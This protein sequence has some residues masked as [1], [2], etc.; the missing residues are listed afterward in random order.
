MTACAGYN[1]P[2]T[3]TDPSG[4]IDGNPGT[5]YSSGKTQ[6]GDESI[7]LTFP[8]SL[9]ATGMT[10]S[11]GASATDFAVMYKLEYSTDGTTFMAFNPA[12][13]GAGT[14]ELSITFPKTTMKAVKLSQTGAQPTGT[15]SWW[16]IH[17]I[18]LTGCGAP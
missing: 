1:I 8:E 11:S 17:E 13:T 2:A 18:A 3:Q 16:S 6:S 7:T 15:T 5:R 14:A 12:V 9:S 10:V 4:A